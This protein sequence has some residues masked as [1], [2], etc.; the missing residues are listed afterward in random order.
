MR[1][2]KRSH[3]QGSGPRKRTAA[4]S[5]AIE[6][7]QKT[8]A[9]TEPTIHHPE[10]ITPASFGSSGS[11][12]ASHQTV[13]IITSLD[14]VVSKLASERDE[15]AVALCSAARTLQRGVQAEIRRLCTPWG[16]QQTEKKASGKHG[17]RADGVLINELKS[18]FIAK[19]TEHFRTISKNIATEQFVTGS[20]AQFSLE[21]AITQTLHRIKAI[22][23]DIEVLARVV[24]HAC[25]SQQCISHVVSAMCQEAAWKTTR[26][27]RNDQPLDA[28]GYIAADAVCRLR[29]AAFAEADG[30]HH[31]RLPDYARQECIDR[32]NKLLHK[33]DLD[34]ILNSDQVNRLVRHFSHLDQRD[35]GPVQ[36]RSITF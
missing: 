35:G 7:T 23:G 5:P 32:G 2:G 33:T 3:E 4:T 18:V 1:P 36:S 26:D 21:S 34:R 11:G 13:I 6:Q 31:M 14:D 27:L 30:W 28:C 10:Y 15:C 19:A 25:H 24:D 29:E 17:R 12:A 16:V 9:N 22:T 20:I 8:P